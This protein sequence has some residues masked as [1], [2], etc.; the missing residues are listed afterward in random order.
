MISYC[1]DC[2]KVQEAGKFC[3]ECGALLIKKASPKLDEEFA[4]L[5]AKIKPQLTAL[6]KKSSDLMKEAVAL[7]DLSGV[8]F[9]HDEDYIPNSFYAKFEGI[10][11]S[12]VERLTDISG[13]CFDNEY[14][15]WIS[16]SDMC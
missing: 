15:G 10:D 11:Y 4:E 8:P 2:T 1:N 16:S 14:S 5:V 13:Y 9:S 7:S 3:Q 12:A 6:L